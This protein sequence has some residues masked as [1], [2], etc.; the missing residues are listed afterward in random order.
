MVDRHVTDPARIAQLLASEVTGRTRGPL[1]ALAVVDADREASPEPGGTPA[2]R[3]ALEPD[4]V[5]ADSRWTD[6]PGTPARGGGAGDHGDDAGSGQP[7]SAPVRLATV[8]LH[9]D[10]VVVTLAPHAAS[11]ADQ[12]SATDADVEAVLDAGEAALPDRDRADVA[13]SR[14][15]GTLAIEVRTGAAVKPAVDVLA[16]GVAALPPSIP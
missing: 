2:Y 15:A 14:D 7:R 3:L 6:D 10:A 1:G 12:S 8:A 4:H 13:V 16:A 11:T 9:P 5:V